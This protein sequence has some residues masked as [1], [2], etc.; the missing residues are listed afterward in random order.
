MTS[1]HLPNQ[2]E[3]PQ[4]GGAKSV[5]TS[6][7]EAISRAGQPAVIG[8]RAW[9]GKTPRRKNHR[10]RRRRWRVRQFNTG[11]R[12]GGA[13]RIARFSHIP[14]NPRGQLVRRPCCLRL[15]IASVSGDARVANAG[16]SPIG[17]PVRGRLPPPA[18]E[19]TEKPLAQDCHSGIAASR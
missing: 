6:K 16:E 4:R 5:V 14:S 2:R 9:R 10:S 18:R 13:V 3:I 12:A 11:R 7:I 8:G 1:P 15:G 19:S 17:R